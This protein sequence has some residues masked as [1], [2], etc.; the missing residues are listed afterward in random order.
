MNKFIKIANRVTLRN[1]LRRRE[2]A[3]VDF[4]DSGTKE[5]Q[6]VKSSGRTKQIPKRSVVSS[7]HT[8]K[9]PLLF[10]V[11]MCEYMIDFINALIAAVFYAAFRSDELLK[12]NNTSKDNKQS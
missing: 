10:P 8:L 7:S 9:A 12:D 2:T 3:L 11:S 5:T 4:R 6:S 1:K